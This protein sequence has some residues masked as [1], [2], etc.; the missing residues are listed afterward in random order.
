MVVTILRGVSGAGKSTYTQRNHPDALVCSADHFFG[1]GED[2]KFDPKKIGQAHEFCFKTFKTAVN[3]QTPSIVV[4]N[5][6]TQKWE[7]ERYVKYAQDNGY[8]VNVVRLKVDPKVAAARNVHGVP[9]ETVMRMQNR[10][11]DFPGETIIG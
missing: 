5:T 6:N 4:D 2:Y 1:H 8:T 3:A 9:F 11:Q 7:F 10:F